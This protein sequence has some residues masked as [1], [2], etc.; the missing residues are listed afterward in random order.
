MISSLGDTSDRIVGLQVGADSY[1]PKPFEPRELVAH[2]DAL[3]RRAQVLSV[4]KA[5][6]VT[7]VGQ[8]RVDFGRRQVTLAG[9]PVEL[10]SAEFEL[11]G[12][13]VSQPGHVFSRDELL[14]RL[15]GIDWEAYNRSVD[16][17]VSRLRKRLGDN[18]KKPTYL[19]TIWG[20]GYVFL[21]NAAE[22]KAG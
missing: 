10:S 20:T 7:E 9:A 22:R 19:K 2:L 13:L 14:N 15:K 17:I 11:L 6:D 16:V 5:Q 1:L 8:L 21:P 18:P 3:L 4:P 12:V